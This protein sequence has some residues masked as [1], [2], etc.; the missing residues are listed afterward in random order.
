VIN[1]LVRNTLL[2]SEIIDE[3]SNEMTIQILINHPEFPVEKATRRMAILAL[4]ANKE[5]ILALKNTDRSA[6]QSIIDAYNDVNRLNLYVVRQLK[7]GVEQNLF[8][9]LGF[10]TPK[11][12]LGYRIVANS[13]KSIADNAVNITD[14]IMALN[15]LI[16]NQTLYLRELIDEELYSQILDFNSLAQQSLEESLKAMFQRNYEHADKIVSQLE[17][18]TKLEHDLVNLMLSKKLDPNV[19]SI[20]R[21]VIDGSRQ[22]VEHGRTIAE[23]TLNRTVEEKCSMQGYQ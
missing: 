18:F 20:F 9:E 23:V 5:A 21:L 12:F 4:S 2:G 13:L 17:S 10:S 7:F 6:V 3:T 16:E 14:N 22:V 11:E 1:N 15:K 19:S 8:K